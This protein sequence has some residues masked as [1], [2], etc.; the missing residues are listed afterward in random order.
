MI[1]KNNI[2]EDGIWDE[3]SSY[4]GNKITGYKYRDRIA[5]SL[6]DLIRDKKILDKIIEQKNTY[7]FFREL[8][9]FLDLK[10]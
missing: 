4:W 6:F 9:D 10:S 5:D 3:M 1:L 8:N 2:L 7:C